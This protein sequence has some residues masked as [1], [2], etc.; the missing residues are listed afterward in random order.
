MLDW[1]YA[2][3]KVSS[4]DCVG[5]IEFI[6]D[7]LSSGMFYPPLSGLVNKVSE[8]GQQKRNVYSQ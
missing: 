3:K 2:S 4:G 8:N 1:I 5:G 6:E 7:K